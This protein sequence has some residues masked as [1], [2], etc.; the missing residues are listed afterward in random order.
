MTSK[1]AGNK[2]A[3]AIVRRACC[4]LCDSKKLE[5]VLHLADSPLADSYIPKERLSEPQPSYPLDLYLCRD[6]GFTQIL[7]VV[8]P[9]VI[10]F[11]YI[12][13]TKSSLGLVEHFKKYADEV[14]A[15]IKPAAG[16]F[17]VDIG[18]N[19]GS[20]LG[21]FK[22]KGLKVL[23]IDPAREIAR[24]ATAAGTETW[25]ELF[26]TALAAKIRAE[27]GAASIIT[28]NNIYANVDDLHDMTNGIRDLLAPDGVFVFESFYLADLMQNMV[29]DFIY[30]EH[31][32]YFSVKPLQAFFKAHGMELID[33]QRIPTKGGSLRY[34]AQLAGGPRKVSPSVAELIAFEESRGLQRPESFHAFNDRIDA[35]KKQLVD[36]LRGLK[37]K[38]KK[39]AGF[40]ASPTTTTLIYHYGIVD[41]LDFIADDNPQRQGLFCPG[42]HIPVLPPSAIAERKPDAVVIIAWRYVAPILK[43]LEAYKRGGG[44]VIVPLP[45]VKTL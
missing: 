8:Q 20:L 11:E 34:T 5:R 17:V 25:A 39:I 26:N 22:A 21:A 9:Q 15:K 16:S 32:S 33:A 40:G 29:F 13:E 42:S 2:A 7:D 37:A 44:Q 28:A 10:Y 4:R 3:D 38:G 43:S 23:G 14:V 31:I 45:E 1:P 18:S 41:L 19:D 12:Y 36:L 6:C 24:K 27:R 35:A 30:H